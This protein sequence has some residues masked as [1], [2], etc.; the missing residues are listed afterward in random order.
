MK[1]I[2]VGGRSFA[3]DHEE[4]IY[5]PKDGLTKSDLMQYYRTMASLVLR[6]IKD[7]PIMM[8]RFPHGIEGEAFYAK[9]APDYFPAWI[10]TK[11]IK[12]RQE[13]GSTNFV[14]C[15]NTATLVYLA[16]QACITLHAWLSKQDKLNYLITLFLI[17]ILHV[18]IVMIFA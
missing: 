15:N 11:Q 4:K 8:Q 3:I 9:N 5:F 6:Y 13:A 1:T 14:I 2:R 17:L 12:K 10:V 18:R 16:S 7:R